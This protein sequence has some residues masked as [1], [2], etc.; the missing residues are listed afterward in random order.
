MAFSHA[1]ITAYEA[2]LQKLQ[3]QKNLLTE[4]AASAGK[5]KK[6]FEETF[7]TSFAFLSNPRVLWDSGRIEHRRKL[8]RLL[9]GGRIQYAVSGGLRTPQTTNLFAALQEFSNDNSRVAQETVWGE[10]VSG[11]RTGYFRR[12]WP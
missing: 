6:S 2:Q 1:A 12:F 8:L 3:D 7:R 11:A 9:F 10:R 4:K 5:P